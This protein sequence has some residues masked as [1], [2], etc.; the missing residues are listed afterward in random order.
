MMKT[1]ENEDSRFYHLGENVIFEDGIEISRPQDVSLGDLT[2]IQRDCFFNIPIHQNTDHPRIEIWENCGI[3]K[4][5]VISAVNRVVIQ[6]SVLI[7]AN[8]HISD[9][10]HEYRKVGIPIMFQGFTTLQKEIVIGRGSW[11]A[12]N[13]VIVGDVHIGRGCVIGANSVVNSDV[14]DY[15]V[16]VGAPARVIKCFD[17]VSGKWLKISRQK[18]LKQLLESRITHKPLLTVAVLIGDNSATLG[19]CLNLICREIGNDDIFEILVCNNDADTSLDEI[20]RKYSLKYG[21]LHPIGNE[22]KLSF[23]EAYLKAIE[24]ACGEFVTIIKGSDHFACNSFY[25]IVNAL[26]EN[27]NYAVLF[28]QS[29]NQV[30]SCKQGHGW[31]NYLN[32]T[33][34]KPYCSSL[35]TLN[36]GRVN[37]LP[38]KDRFV[39][40]GLNHV[41]LQYLLLHRYANYCVVSGN[42]LLDDESNPMQSEQDGMIK[43]RYN[44]M[45]KDLKGG[46]T[47]K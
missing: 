6:D 47:P 22:G 27:Q 11:I 39:G 44:A 43:E 33:P 14:P 9:H 24:Q 4:R 3:G 37:R 35:A 30:F 17:R 15:C 40:S 5:C 2:Y 13:C 1:A 23:D 25:H 7:G 28:L 20:I 31:E 42:T 19:G 29:V 32:D 10:D 45:L 34:Q 12:N 16:A 8:V 38:N 36:L 46:D 18:Q 21:N 26:Y 41:Y